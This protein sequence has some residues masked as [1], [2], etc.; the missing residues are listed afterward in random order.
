[1]GTPTNVTCKH[2]SLK[3]IEPD[4]LGENIQPDLFEDLR[5]FLK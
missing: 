4:L 3:R 1:M 5:R 2:E